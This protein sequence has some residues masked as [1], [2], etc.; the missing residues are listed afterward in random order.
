MT[1]TKLHCHRIKDGVRVVTIKE[2]VFVLMRPSKKTCKVKR[3]QDRAWSVTEVILSPRI[4][5]SWIGA[6]FI[7][8]DAKEALAQHCALEEILL[9]LTT[10]AP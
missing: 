7:L 10:E 9:P 4:G 2:Q 1:S 8:S 3:V 5:L 6:F